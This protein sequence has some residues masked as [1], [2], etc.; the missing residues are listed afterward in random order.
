[1]EGMPS[2]AVGLG[3][4]GKPLDRAQLNYLREKGAQDAKI[5]ASAAKQ[6]ELDPIKKHLLDLGGVALFP[7][8]KKILNNKVAETYNYLMENS[9]NLDQGAIGQ[10]LMGIENMSSQF[11]SD[12]NSLQK[13]QFQGGSKAL[14][15]QNSLNAMKS[16]EDVDQ[17]NSVL[18]QQPGAEGWQV[19]PNDYGFKGVA[20]DYTPISETVKTYIDKNFDSYLQEVNQG[21]GVSTVGSNGKEFANLELK[22]EAYDVALQNINNNPEWSGSAS[23]DFSMSPEGRAKSYDLSTDKGITEFYTDRDNW[24][25]NNIIKPEFD[26]RSK[27]L[28]IAKPMSVTVNAGDEAV[29]GTMAPF[30]ANV[31]VKF[32]DQMIPVE[33]A[34]AVA[35]SDQ[36]FTLPNVVETRNADGKKINTTGKKLTY[37]FVASSYTLDKPLKTKYGIMPAGMLVPKGYEQSFVNLGAEFSPKLLAWAQDPASKEWIYT[38]SKPANQAM[39]MK[40]SKQDKQIITRVT[41]SQNDLLERMKGYNSKYGDPT[42][43]S[44]AG[45]NTNK[46]VDSIVPNRNKADEEKEAARKAKGGRTIT[47]QAQADKEALR[48]KLNKGVK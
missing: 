45:G 40:A 8:Q 7:Y 24:V 29:Q 18:G 32:G 25:K 30:D 2:L 3:L 42:P 43:K 21:L 33:T 37:N 38:P 19:D 16:I 36:T 47:T 15:F 26:A 34:G 48:R 6:K 4:Q 14:P 39:F 13:L 5:K 1:M 17:L 28:G 20:Y 23:H 9:D 12:Y 31:V 27:S 35:F 10:M 22:P 46:R 41:E 11:K 44:V